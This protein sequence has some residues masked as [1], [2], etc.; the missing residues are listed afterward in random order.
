LEVA[1][2]GD[3]AAVEQLLKNNVSVNYEDRV[4]DEIPPYI[5][6]YADTV[7]TTV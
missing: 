1:K 3:V 4:R 6:F 5:D 7:V 2:K